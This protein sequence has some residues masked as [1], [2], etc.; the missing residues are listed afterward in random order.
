MPKTESHRGPKKKNESL[1]LLR[2]ITKSMAGSLP[3]LSQ[4]TRDTLEDS[5]A[6]PI[7]GLASQFA[8]EL[9]EEKGKLVFPPLENLKRSWNA[10]SRRKQ[11]LPPQKKVMPGIV[12]DTLSVPSMFGGGPQWA[13]DA[14]ESADRI[15]AA[16]DEGMGLAPPQG[17]RQHA[18]NSAGMMAAQIPVAGKAKEIPQAAR[19]ALE[20]MKKYGKKA[21]MSPIEF[22]SPTIEPKMSNYLFGSAAGGALGTLGDEAAEMA[23]ETPP[24]RAISRAKGGKVGALKQI[25]RAISINPDSTVKQTKH[26]IGD[27]VEEVLY[28]TNEGQ[29]KGV[30]SS[31]EAKYIKG[32]LMTGEEE[33]L[34]DALFEL[35]SRLFPTPRSAKEPTLQAMPA[36]EELVFQTQ[37]GYREPVHGTGK[38]APV[39]PEVPLLK[40]GKGGKASI[41]S[42]LLETLRRLDLD[43]DEFDLLD[44]QGNLRI[45]EA[46]AVI[47]DAV[48]GERGVDDFIEDLGTEDPTEITRKIQQQVAPPRRLP[49]QGEVP[50]SEWARI[51]NRM[52][53]WRVQSVFDLEDLMPTQTTE[54]LRVKIP[55]MNKSEARPKKLDILK[56]PKSQKDV[57]RWTGRDVKEIRFMTDQDGNTYVWDAN[58]AIHNQVIQALGLDRKGLFHEMSDTP[59]PPSM[60]DQYFFTNPW[61]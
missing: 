40:R 19:G 27:P 42:K 58:Q 34:S 60:F 16:V 49:D 20:I 41:A 17:F 52:K 36:K 33:K 12:Q 48:E 25:L 3:G 2:A 14:S 11:G 56:N 24:P 50:D 61:E 31:E 37:K 4:E 21:A 22:F 13:Q 1:E 26:M 51:R 18:L 44:E 59:I 23:E 15:H 46:K 7:S 10:D 29:R 39:E 53:D 55:S 38:L 45:D 6:R 54:E 35:H 57:E 28:A 30:L 32:L 8:G 5:L 9:P 47:E 43:P